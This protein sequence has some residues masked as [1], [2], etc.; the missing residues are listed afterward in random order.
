MGWSYEEYLSQPQEF[1]L[2]LYELLRAES[3]HEK[4]TVQ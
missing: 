1:T 4:N 2:M 3:E